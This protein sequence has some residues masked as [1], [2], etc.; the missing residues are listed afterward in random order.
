MR[1]AQDIIEQFIQA[2]ILQEQ[3][4]LRLSFENKSPDVAYQ[5]MV[6]LIFAYNLYKGFMEKKEVEALLDERV[7]ALG[8]EQ[9]NAPFWQN[10]QKE[11]NDQLVELLNLE[12][13]R[14]EL[15]ENRAKSQEEK[16]KYA[17]TIKLFDSFRAHVQE[18]RS[19]QDVLDDQCFYTILFQEEKKTF[20]AILD[21]AVSRDELLCTLEALKSRLIVQKQNKAAEY[22]QEAELQLQ[23]NELDAFLKSIQEAFSY[24]LPKESLIYE[25]KKLEKSDNIQKD[26]GPFL[27]SF[28]AA[29]G[30][31]VPDTRTRIE[32]FLLFLNQKDTPYSSLSLQA[33]EFE[34]LWRAPISDE[35][36]KEALDFGITYEKSILD[37]KQELPKAFDETS[38][39]Y[40]QNLEKD[41]P[42]LPI[43]KE[44]KD[45]LKKD[46]QA[47]FNAFR[48]KL[49]VKR[50]HT[51]VLQLL[52]KIE[53]ML[54]KQQEEQ[55]SSQA[56]KPKMI[57]QMNPNNLL[58]KPQESIRLLQDME[59][60]D[61][62]TQPESHNVTEVERP[63]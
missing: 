15:E 39:T 34:L 50:K 12:I 13:K 32:Q 9:L 16:S 11:R 42:S 2:L 19:S 8:N 23:Q 26:K 56:E 33:I 44:D 61:E 3:A 60:E 30:H 53:R 49:D 52:E 36:F 21:N 59:A 14:L 41:E 31:L 20:K 48:S 54:Q 6:R 63:W 40:V 55:K 25:L 62:S 46:F 38:F 22:I 24:L 45:E 4:D 29:K 18:E 51:M 1:A 35:D 28:D 47:V 57:E 27:F 17:L 43:S 7:Q 5:H 58:L 10:E 37:L